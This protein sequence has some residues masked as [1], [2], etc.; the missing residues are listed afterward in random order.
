VSS[1][2]C[3]GCGLCCKKFEVALKLEEWLKV[4]RTYG[5]GATGAGLNNLCLGKKPDGT[6]IFL[7]TLGGT[8]FC[9]LQNMKPLACKLWPFKIIG[10]PKYGRGQEALF[11]YKGRR[12]FIYVDPFCPEIRWGNPEPVTVHNVIPEFIEI[13]LGLRRKQFYSTAMPLYSLYP[14]GKLDYR[15]V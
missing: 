10:R 1:W 8:S 5:I 9:G 11:D 12:L 14:K 7:S 4:V 15:T 13:A 2:R 6:C 3:T